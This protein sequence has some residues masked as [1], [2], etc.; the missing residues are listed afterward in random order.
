MK[1]TNRSK[2]IIGVLSM[3]A[4]ATPYL[5]AAPTEGAV[6]CDKCKIVMVKIAIPG[7]SKAP[8]AVYHDTKTMICPDCKSAMENFFTTGSLKHTCTACGGAMTHCI[9]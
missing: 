3:I 9:H 5:N 7:T 4:I 6:M 2:L 1:N 8:L